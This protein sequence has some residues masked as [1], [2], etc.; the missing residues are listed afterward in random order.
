M[1][2][3]LGAE[4]GLDAIVR[5]ESSGTGAWHVGQDADSRMRKT[6]ARHGVVFHH[7]A[8]MIETRDLREQDIIFAMDRGHYREITAMGRHRLDGDFNA[9]IYMFRQFDPEVAGGEIVPLDRAPDVPDPYYGGA[10]LFEEVYSIVERTSSR[11]LDAI[12]A[13]EL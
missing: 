2:E 1:L 4:R 3:H 13:G 10:D 7:A 8:R 6:A 9:K 11:I 5:V 12:E